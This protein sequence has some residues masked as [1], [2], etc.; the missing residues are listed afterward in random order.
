MNLT[1][2]LDDPCRRASWLPKNTQRAEVV[3]GKRGGVFLRDP[4]TQRT[5][6]IPWMHEWTRGKWKGEVRTPYTLK[7]LPRDQ[8]A[9]EYRAARRQKT[10]EDLLAEDDETT[11]GE[12]LASVLEINGFERFPPPQHQEDN[13]HTMDDILANNADL[14]DLQQQVDEILEDAPP[15][16]QPSVAPDRQKRK[17]SERGEGGIYRLDTGNNLPVPETQETLRKAR[18]KY[19]TRKQN[20]ETFKL[21]EEQGTL[22]DYIDTTQ[23]S[24]EQKA[25]E[26]DEDDEEDSE[27]KRVR[28]QDFLEAFP[29][30]DTSTTKEARKKLKGKNTPNDFDVFQFFVPDPVA[31]APTAPTPTPDPEPQ[32][33]WFSRLGFF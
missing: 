24:L 5:A 20:A 3:I 26:N 11:D 15:P 17:R 4:V 25:R 23:Q 12:G 10:V 16:P 14:E 6:R 29:E 33:S 31:P 19:Y 28:G 9:P 2:P 1:L 7:V 32:Q 13:V 21:I 27:S 30:F 18:R 22:E 8:V